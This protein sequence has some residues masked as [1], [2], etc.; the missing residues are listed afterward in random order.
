MFTPVKWQRRCR[1]ARDEFSELKLTCLIAAIA[2]V[3]LTSQRVYTLSMARIGPKIHLHHS[4]PV[5]FH[6]YHTFPS[7]SSVPA[8]T[9]ITAA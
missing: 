5:L 8:T 7:G 1:F 2:H 3:C 6:P 4:I 9:V